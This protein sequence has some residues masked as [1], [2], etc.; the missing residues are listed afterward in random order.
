MEGLESE[1]P[2]ARTPDSHPTNLPPQPTPLGRQK[3]RAR[4]PLR[5][6]PAARR[7]PAHPHGGRRGREDSP[8]RPGLDRT[9]RGD[10]RRRVLCHPGPA[11]RPRARP[12]HDRPR[13]DVKEQPGRSPLET[14]AEYL[15]E[16]ELVLLLDNFEHL[17]PAAPLVAELLRAAPKLSVLA[18]SRAYATTTSFAS[19]M[20]QV[21]AVS[22]R[23]FWRA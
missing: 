9:P 11:H 15:R 13:L 4:G 5:P 1:L 22:R 23:R 7:A 2:P 19:A 21:A 18:T 3:A 20:T 8:R 17:L 12:A 10:P 14:L 16:K 6:P